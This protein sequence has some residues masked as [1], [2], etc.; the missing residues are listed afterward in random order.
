LAQSHPQVFALD[1]ALAHEAQGFALD[2]DY[3]WRSMV[4]VLVKL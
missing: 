4:T 1:R 2:K 3:H